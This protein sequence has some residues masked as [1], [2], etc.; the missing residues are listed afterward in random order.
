MNVTKTDGL[1]D[2]SRRGTYPLEC[3]QGEVQV[4][5]GMGR[6]E[7]ATDPGMAMRHHGVPEPGDEHTLRKQQVAH[8]DRLSSLAQDHRHDG[9]L[10]GEGLEAQRRQL[11]AE[12]VR[13]LAETPH[14]LR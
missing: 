1:S 3:G 11:A 5:P 4:V 12:V 8:L 9:R 13:V 2:D 7:L 6:R 10:A 14:E